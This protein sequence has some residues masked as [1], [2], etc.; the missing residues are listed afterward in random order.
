M[1][2][3]STS[4]T[5][6]RISV[7]RLNE[8]AEVQFTGQLGFIAENSPWVAK[9][10]WQARP[11]ASVDAVVEAFRIAIESAPAERQLALVRAH[12]DLVGKAALAGSLNP[13]S[14][15]EQSSAGLADLSHAEVETFQRLNA[16]YMG[17]FGFPFVIC[18]RENKKEA[19]LAGFEVRLRHTAEAEMRTALGE[20]A[21]IMRLR[22]LDVLEPD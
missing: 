10:A 8:M 17:R 22:L 4:Q 14:R 19:I 2:E 6:P 3:S 12:P 16:E 18:A 15:H 20:I 7:S 21:K 1:P 9:E 13:Q 5:S 11:F